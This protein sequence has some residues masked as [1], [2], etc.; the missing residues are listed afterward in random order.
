[1]NL[2]PKISWLVIVAIALLGTARTSNAQ[3]SDA[4]P[5]ERERGVQLFKQGDDKQAIEVLNSVVKKGKSDSEAFYYLGLALT[6]SNQ[7]SKGKRAFEAAVKLR[8]DFGPAHTGFAYTLMLS[9]RDNEAEREARRALE[10]NT[11]D[12]EA[13]YVLGVVRLHQRLGPAA[14]AEADAAIKYRPNLAAAYLLKSEALLA[15][16]SDRAATVSR[17]VT[18]EPDSE[19]RKQERERGR[20]LLKGSADA[21]ETYLK[22]RPNKDDETTWREQLATLRVFTGDDG[23]TIRSAD[24]TTR[25]RV[26]SKPEPS[27]TESAR[28]AGVSGTVILRAVFAADGTV[29]HLLVLRSL[30]YG[31]TERSL[32]AARRIK[33]TPATKDGKPISTF[34]QLEYNFNLY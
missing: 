28:Q 6:R 16:Y 18:V 27:Y 11:Y 24:A 19:A 22:L 31:L 1:M 20:R 34:M 4:N 30:P 25:A 8:P 13:H 33:F 29:K 23:G 26:L 7:I 12:A 14:E 9:G 10:L 3:T 21:L 15:Q 2:S 5:S 17:V 32:A